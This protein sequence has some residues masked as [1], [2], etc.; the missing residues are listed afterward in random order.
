MA[1]DSLRAGR[2]RRARASSSERESCLRK[3][4]EIAQDEAVSSELLSEGVFPASREKCRENRIFAVTRTQGQP[5]SARRIGL[6]REIP[7]STEQGKIM[8]E[9]GNVTGHA[10]DRQARCFW[11]D[12]PEIRALTVIAGEHD[13]WDFLAGAIWFVQSWFEGVPPGPSTPALARI[14]EHSLRPQPCPRGLRE[15]VFSMMFFVFPPLVPISEASLS[16]DVR[17]LAGT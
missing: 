8:A 4:I 10:D 17:A 12:T 6:L 5:K 7:Y 11:S 16:V 14:C 13:T 3:A 1:S 9:Q 15:L 2:E